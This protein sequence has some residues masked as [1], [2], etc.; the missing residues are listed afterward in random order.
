MCYETKFCSCLSFFHSGIF[1]YG[2][3]EKEIF[4]N[5]LQLGLSNQYFTGHGGLS[6]KTLQN[7]CQVLI[8]ATVT[9]EIGYKLCQIM[10]S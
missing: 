3:I 8:F 6:K 1:E 4:Q 5:F 9:A 2:D 7:A 10:Q